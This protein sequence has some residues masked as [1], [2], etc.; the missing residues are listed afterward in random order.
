[1][2]GNKYGFYIKYDEFDNIT[3][4]SGYFIDLGPVSKPYDEPTWNYIGTVEHYKKYIKD[5]RMG[6]FVE[7]YMTANGHLFQRCVAIGNGWMS[8][9][10]VNWVPSFHEE[11]VMDDLKMQQSF[12][13]DENMIQY[14]IGGRLGMKDENLTRHGNLRAFDLYRDVNKCVIPLSL[15]NLNKN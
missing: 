12:K 11:A 2:I 13:Y 14:N 6:G 1:M 4:Y 5:N 15:K 3:H 9:D 10:G 8:K 7:N